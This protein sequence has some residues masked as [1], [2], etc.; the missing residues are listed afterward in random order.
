M[1][2]F[3]ILFN[4]LS[5]VNRIHDDRNLLAEFYVPQKKIIRDL[6]FF[7]E[8]K[9]TKEQFHGIDTSITNK[10]KRKVINFKSLC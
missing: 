9:L 8:Q 3:E 6:F 2:I 7:N 4:L 1:F 5:Y 10:C